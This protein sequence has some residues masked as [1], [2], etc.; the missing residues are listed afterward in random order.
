M[1]RNSLPL[2]DFELNSKI[3]PSE[4]F[5]GIVFYHSLI[6]PT[7]IWFAAI[8]FSNVKNNRYKLIL[9]SLLFAVALL[10]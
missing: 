5:M 6:M 8:N 1:V 2:F 10:Y 9:P 4:Q 3:M 7:L